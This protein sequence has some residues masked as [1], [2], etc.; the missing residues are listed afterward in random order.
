[1]SVLQVALSDLLR[2]RWGRLLAAIA[3][4]FVVRP[5]AADAE[6]VD[7]LAI[8]EYSRQFDVGP[9][10]A[11]A[12]LELQAKAAGIS[13]A[14]SRLLGSDYAGVW[15]DDEEGQYVVPVLSRA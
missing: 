15:F 8:D 11:A 4:L 1:M 5:G 14:L 12:R 7:P 9:G 13:D 10:E 6:E 3:L 2:R